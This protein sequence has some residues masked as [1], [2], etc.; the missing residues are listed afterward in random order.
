MLAFEAANSKGDISATPEYAYMHLVCKDMI[1]AIELFEFAIK[2]IVQMQR[3]YS[4]LGGF[5]SEEKA[6]ARKQTSSSARS[7]I[8]QIRTHPG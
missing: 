1:Q 7:S 8:D 2:V 3:L 6:M 4:G 5:E